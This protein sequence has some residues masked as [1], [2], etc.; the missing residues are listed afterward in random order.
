MDL[1][2]IEALHPTHEAEHGLLVLNLEHG[3]ANEIGTE[4]LDALTSLCELIEHDASV[5]CLCTTSRRVSRS[6]KPIFIAGAN[7]TERTGW[8]DDRVKNHVVRQRELMR[9]L[10]HL[11]IFTVVLSHGVTLGWGTEYVLTADYTLATP[12]ASFALPE[13]GLGIL[14]GARGTAELAAVVGA[15][16]AL[17]LGCTGESVAAEE[18]LRIGL[19]QEL[20]PDVDAGLVRARA[21]SDLLRR[22]SPTAVAAYKRALLEASGREEAARL[23]LERAAY[24]H[25]VDTGEAAIGRASFGAIRAGETPPWGPR[26]VD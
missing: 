14:P 21:L 23:A 9:R 2:G 17:R 18:A 19:V 1:A 12:T 5:A 20:V 6:G 10:R 8:D 4:Q 24:E 25:C 13:T 3:K 26:R 22:R 15:S 7:V 16:Q 11:P